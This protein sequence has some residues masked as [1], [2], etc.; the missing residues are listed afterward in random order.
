MGIFF[1]FFTHYLELH[2]SALMCFLL[3][4]LC[5]LIAEETEGE[6]GLIAQRRSI[7]LGSQ[8]SCSQRA[9]F[10]EALCL[11][12]CAE[13]VSIPRRR[14]VVRLLRVERGAWVSVGSSLDV[15][16]TA[17]RLLEPRVWWGM[18]GG[19]SPGEGG[20]DKL[21]CRR[22]P[23]CRL[24]WYFVGNVG[25]VWRPEKQKWSWDAVFR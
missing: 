8:L 11:L 7:R 22:C 23:L 19:H 13:D 2:F 3:W 24:R 6:C 4:V 10:L 9:S 20:G 25:S 16:G 5:T 17:G 21:K 1:F 18:V 15:R 14:K 12:S